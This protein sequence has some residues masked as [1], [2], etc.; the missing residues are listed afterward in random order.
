MHISYHINNETQFDTVWKVFID[1]GKV[2]E[3]KAELYFHN[4]N[5]LLQP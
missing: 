4:L 1:I 2:D 5:V 3:Y